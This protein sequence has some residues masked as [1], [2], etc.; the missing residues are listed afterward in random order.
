MMPAPGAAVLASAPGKLIV[1]GEH[2]AVYGRPAV[3]AALGLRVSVRLEAL[4]SP[5]LSAAAADG[6]RV[7]IDLPDLGHRA[8]VSWPE[9]DDYTR[10]ARR[11]WEEYAESPTAQRFD[12]LCGVDPAHVVKVALGE[13]SATFSGVADA[14][15]S[16]RRSGLAV[17]IDSQIPVG[18][19]FGSSAAVAVAV[20]AAYRRFC[21][22]ADDLA[23]VARLALEVERRQHGRPS[24][25]DH[26][27]VLHGGVVWAAREADG[28]LS[29]E[30]LPDAAERLGAIR[31]YDSGDPGEA[32]GQAVEAVRDRLRSRPDWAAELLDGMESCVRDCRR[33][34]GRGEAGRRGEMTKQTDEAS[35]LRELV[36][37]YEAMLEELGVVPAR[38]RAI[39]R[40]VEALGG[41]AKISGAGSVSGD[42]AGSLLVVPPPVAGPDLF[43]T[44]AGCQRIVADLGA[45]GLR[46]ETMQ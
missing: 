36:R 9:I 41:A 31:I 43:N 33:R 13:V 5:R 17:R 22:L 38:V 32:T 25:V 19:G 26:V 6:G 37:T 40:A 15:G 46:L 4:E 18:S 23:E 21:G 10:R 11:A 28:E 7:T 45:P 14:L 8:Q 3:V 44:L 27:A 12:S 1:M 29:I 16:R 2:A 34:L 24:G 20:V 39:I 42:G 30:S 35:G